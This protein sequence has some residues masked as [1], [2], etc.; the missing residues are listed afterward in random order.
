VNKKIW[1]ILGVA[2]VVTILL[3]L[4]S[5]FEPYSYADE[6]IYLVLGKAW[7]QGLVFYRD[8]HDNKPPLLY[9]TAGLAKTV[10]G[11]RVILL[12]WN[13]VN[14]W[15]VWLLGRKIFKDKVKPIMVSCL[16][17]VLLSSLSFWEGNMANGEIFMIMPFTMAVYLILLGLERKKNWYFGV[18]GLLVAVAFLYKVPVM[19]DFVGVGL[20]LLWD[21]WGK[22]GQQWREL[23]KQWSVLAAGF[24]L[25]NILVFWYY[26]SVGAGERYLMSALLQN[27]P[28]LSSWGGA[29]AGGGGLW[30][31]GLFQRGLVVLLLVGLVFWKRK[32][33]N[34][35][36]GLL[37]LWFVFSLY[38]VLLPGRPY[39]HYFLE[40]V[41][42]LSLITGWLTTR[43]RLGRTV[44]KIAW[45]LVVLSYGVYRFW[46]YPVGSYYFNFWQWAVGLKDDANYQRYWGEQILVD[47]QVGE[48]IGQLTGPEEKIYVWGTA[49]GIYYLAD[50]LPVGRYT[51]AYHVADFDAYD[52]TMTALRQEEPNLIIKLRS[53]NLPFPALGELLAEEYSL[54]KTIG[55]REIYLRLME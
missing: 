29:S 31:N 55:D 16:L 44:V 22:M 39:S 21:K 34:R 53:E 45:G 14:L 47:Q 10:W 33:M 37:G 54:T 30:Q 40:L 4:P 38:G 43:D 52:E 2:A 46:W 48:Y 23:L 51:V 7:R 41:V 6:G 12:A 3:R 25:P 17:F 24:L 42:V 15:L 20:W 18:S 8:I 19:F 49:P 13:L 35:W 5:L 11:F 26:W 50:R 9:V 28:Y 36:L 1:W 32:K 27:L